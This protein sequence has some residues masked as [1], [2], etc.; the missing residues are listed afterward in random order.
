MERTLQ[1]KDSHFQIYEIKNKPNPLFLFHH[2]AGHTL[3]SWHLLFEH[4]SQ[5]MEGWFVSYDC[6]GH[7]NTTTTNDLD[8][9]L[10]TLSNDL[11]DIVEYLK[12]DNIVLVGHSMG[13]AVVV[14]AANR[15][16]LSG[17]VVVDVV[18]G[19]ALEALRHMNYFLS[20]RPKSFQSEASAIQWAISSNQVKNIES[21]KRS[22]PAQIQF[23]GSVYVWKT[24]LQKT[25]PYWHG[26]FQDLS[27]KFLSC[28]G[29]R[30]LVLAGTDRLDKTLLIG[31]MQGKFQL[32][33]LPEC[34]HSVQEDQPEKLALLLSEFWNRNQPLKNIKRFP[35][36]ERKPVS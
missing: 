15:L 16:K 27:A 18:E 1:I 25:Q 24:D 9:S 2:G 22:I 36:P 3:H 8:L 14:N 10:E 33:I 34:G 29:A 23:N 12:P 28:R 35:I 7:G 11:V 21:A 17:V 13:G 20:N 4:L 31:Q 32:E 19:T 5:T 30:L 26:W 6:R